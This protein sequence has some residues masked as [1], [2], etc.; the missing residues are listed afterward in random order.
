MYKNKCEQEYIQRFLLGKWLK[1]FALFLILQLFT[2]ICCLLITNTTLLSSEF[3]V[4]PFLKE[5]ST[6]SRPCLR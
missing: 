3:T 1:R 5:E 6:T 2:A 4:A